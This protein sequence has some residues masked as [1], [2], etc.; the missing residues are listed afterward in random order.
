MKSDP[1]RLEEIYARLPEAERRSLLD[2]AE[3]LSQRVETVESRYGVIPK[4]RLI[5]A[6]DEETVVGAIKRLSASYFMLDKAKM[7]DKTSMLVTQHV[8]QG[9]DKQEVIEELEGIF[10]AHY[11]K[12]LDDQGNKNQL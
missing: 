10:Q 5:R 11:Q 9:R 12:L 4:P 6:D 1:R 7:L 2:Y 3:F 8:M